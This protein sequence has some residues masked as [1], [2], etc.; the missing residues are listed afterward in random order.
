MYTLQLQF[1][2]RIFRS[3]A[4]VRVVGE[5]TDL[6]RQFVVLELELSLIVAFHERRTVWMVVTEM[7]VVFFRILRHVT[8]ILTDVHLGSSFLVREAQLDVVYFTGVRLQ[9]TPLGE[10]LVTHLA[11][12]RSDA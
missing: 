9:G 1:R 4:G 6:D 7:D 2:Y 8:A 5:D 11:F 3:S 10:R 12:I